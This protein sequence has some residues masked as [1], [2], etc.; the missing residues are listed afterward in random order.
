MVTSF[1]GPRVL[2]TRPPGTGETL[3]AAL[4]QMG[5]SVMEIPAVEIHGPIDT[6]SVDAA[7]DRLTSYQWIAFTSRNA[8]DFFLRRM[9]ERTVRLPPGIR[10]AAVGTSTAALLEDQGI[11]VECVPPA[12][13]AAALAA[14]MIRTGAAGARVLIPCGDRSRPDLA[15]GLRSGGA[16]VDTLVAYRTVTAGRESRERLV[17]ALEKGQIDVVALASPS[18]LDGIAAA[19]DGNLRPLR[20]VRLVCIGPTTAE[21]VRSAGLVPTAVADPHTAAGLAAAIAGLFTE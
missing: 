7:L 8:V 6:R 12:A 17:A 3:R 14:E 18:A 11:S 20:D 15:N 19:L 16:E 5:A 2:I 21:A 13:S 10:V 9:E 4:E 1:V